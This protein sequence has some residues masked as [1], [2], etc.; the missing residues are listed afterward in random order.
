MNNLIQ[1]F[2]KLGLFL[3]EFK[4]FYAHEKY[5]SGN[6][7]KFFFPFQNIIKKIPI[8]NSWF[9]TEDLFITIEQ[10]GK[11][12]TK[13]KL[14]Y[15]LNKYSFIKKKNQIKTILVI[16]PGNIPIVGFH[17]FLCVLLSGHRILIKLSEEDN[18]LLPFLGKI[19]TH[20]N[21]L[22]E[23][24][25]KFSKNFFK[26]KY[27]SVIASCSNNTARYFEYYFRK[28]PMILRKRRTSIAILQGNES[29]KDLISL[30]KDILTYSGRGC[31][32]VGKIFIPNNYDLHLI[33]D[34]N[35]LSYVM[36]NYKY[37][38]NYNYYLSIY[39]LNNIVIKRNPMMI[40][41][42]NKDYHSPISVVYYEFYSNLNQLKK[43]IHK[44]RKHLQ[45]LVS[46]N[47]C[48][49]EV[50]FGKTQFPKLWDYSDNIDTMKFLTE[51]N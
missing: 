44:N 31:R 50:D 11:I 35:L 6:F 29:K 5:I 18:L 10:W 15:W 1:T 30:N 19:I 20:I 42:E 3:R 34:Q 38:D 33:L 14:E 21:P 13:E 36:K 47:I 24:K 16:M 2:D 27:D 46:R 40:L 45:C 48:K 32:N 23:K 41:I 17:D 8:I 4:K 28:Y 9:R 39:T 51:K 25:I 22:L 12:L 26:E 49:N 37:I 7:K 43:L